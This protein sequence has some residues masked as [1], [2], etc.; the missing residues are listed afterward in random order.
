MLFPFFLSPPLVIHAS[1][2]GAAG[3]N[4]DPSA[5]VRA[6]DQLLA[7]ARTATGTYRVVRGG[8]VGRVDFALEKPNALSLRSAG[9]VDVFDGREHIISY[10]GENG[11]ERRDAGTYGVPYLIGFTPFLDLS[12]PSGTVPS[13]LP[14]FDSGRA[15]IFD[16]RTVVRRSAQVNGETIDVD[17]DPT[18]KLPIRWSWN[19]GGES[20]V[21]VFEN[22]V[23]DG[24][25]PAGTFDVA[26]LTAG[27]TVRP[28]P[29]EASLL[30]I[31]ASAPSLSGSDTDGRRFSLASAMTGKRATV[32]A[33]VTAGDA[34]SAD[35][36]LALGNLARR[37]DLRDVA[38]VAAVSSENTAD[39]KLL[40][41]NTRFGGRGFP[42]RSL[43]GQVVVDAR[44]GFGVV[45][46]LS[47]VVLDAAGKVRARSI[48]YDE[49]TLLSALDAKSDT[50]PTATS[51]SGG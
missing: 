46:P 41:K 14:K 37:R 5:V 3:Q 2:L 22:V 36:L 40:L 50:M 16:G 29:E 43:E 32:L 9:R 45:T 17:L 10:P 51:S 31:G 33:F 44:R 7:N 25:I 12:A 18:T 27:R 28:T 8:R 13:V 48:G 34:R 6:S 21:A 4:V 1:G 47:I 26:A 30:G 20:I 15:T 24:A 19:H 42:G 49:A 23:L 39:T 38:I 11:Y 35:A